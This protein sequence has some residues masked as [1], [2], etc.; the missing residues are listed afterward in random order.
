MENWSNR[1]TWADK[2]IL[3]QQRILAPYLIQIGEILD[4]QTKCTDLKTVET[5]TSVRIRKY[6]D[7]RYKNE[8]T[9]R[10][11]SHGITT[12]LEKI[13]TGWGDYILYCFANQDET[14]IDFWILGD[15]NVFRSIIFN[16]PKLMENVRNNRD[17]TKF[18]VFNWN[19]F[20][21]MIIANA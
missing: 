21:P 2:F 17:G 14:N 20:K 6:A 19:D 18:C 15:L 7:L 13:A 9:I 10:S 4:D 1:K 12:E 8:F 5:R 11:Y 3:Q 16:N